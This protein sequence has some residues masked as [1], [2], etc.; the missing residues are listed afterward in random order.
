M[1]NSKV[2]LSMENS[3]VKEARNAQGR[4]LVGNRRIIRAGVNSK[5]R[6]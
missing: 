2:L 6:S 4:K 3:T 1:K 5:A